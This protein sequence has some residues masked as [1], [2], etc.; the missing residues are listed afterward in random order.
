MK[1]AATPYQAIS[2]TLEFI[3]AI[4]CTLIYYYNS[5]HT[6]LARRIFTPLI[7]I[8]P[9]QNS[10]NIFRIVTLSRASNF[11]KLSFSFCTNK[12]E[13]PKTSPPLLVQEGKEKLIG[14]WLFLSAAAVLGMIVLGGYTRLTHS[15][16]SMADWSPYTKRFP[17]NDEEW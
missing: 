11:S 8:R 6:M 10:H 16:L 9:F 4:C 7:S 15:G 2:D 12:E 5:D 17:R 1:P 14:F 13:P 3:R